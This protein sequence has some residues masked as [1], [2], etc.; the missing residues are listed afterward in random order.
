MLWQVLQKWRVQNS[1]Y[2]QNVVYGYLG[3]YFA[4][5][6]TM[7]NGVATGTNTGILSPYG[8]FTPTQPGPIALLTMPDPNTG[9]RG[10]GVVMSPVCN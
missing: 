2:G 1:A 7:T 3:Q 4:G 8:N 9:A 10:T 6:Y 5:A